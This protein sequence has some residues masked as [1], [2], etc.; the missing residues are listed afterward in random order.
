MSIA[1]EVVCLL[2]RDGLLAYAAAVQVFS[3]GMR[4]TA[5]FRSSSMSIAAEA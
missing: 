3:T 5:C 1:T 4:L 2:R